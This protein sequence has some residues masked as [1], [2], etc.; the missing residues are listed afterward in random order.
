MFL[1]IVARN[2][3]VQAQYLYR[4]LLQEMPRIYIDRGCHDRVPTVDALLDLNAGG[5]LAKLPVEAMRTVY[6][7]DYIKGVCT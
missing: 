4:V 5:Q 1:A 3:P 2:L 6:N 7:I